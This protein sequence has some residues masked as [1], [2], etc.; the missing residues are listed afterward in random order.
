MFEPDEFS[1]ARRGGGGGGGGSR[2]IGELPPILELPIAPGMGEER[3]EL[4][5]EFVSSLGRED[6]DESFSPLASECGAWNCDLAFTGCQWSS[7][8]S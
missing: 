5:V 6:N 3:A 4:D 8:L 2:F 7:M 1:G